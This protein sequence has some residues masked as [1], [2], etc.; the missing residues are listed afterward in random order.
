MATDVM[1]NKM[2]AKAGVK[3]FREQIIASMFK[4]FKHIN[5]G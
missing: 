2:N 4:K 5:D 1:F 3:K